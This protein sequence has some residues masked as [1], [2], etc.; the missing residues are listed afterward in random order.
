MTE[1]QQTAKAKRKPALPQGDVPSLTVLDTLRVARAIADHLAKAPS[2]PLHVAAAMGVQP[3]TGGFRAITAASVA[4]GLT[5]G[6]AWAETISLTD[7]GRRAVAPTTEGDDAAALREAVLR[8]RLIREFL[9]RYDGSKWPRDDIAANVLEQMGAPAAQT[10]RALAII[11]QNAQDLGLLTSISGVDYV[12][13]NPAGGPPA[14][15]AGPPAAAP[16]PPGP[17]PAVRPAAAVPAGPA[18]A[19]ELPP[20]AAPAP[21]VQEPPPVVRNENRRVFITHGKDKAIVEQIKMVLAYGD[22]EPVVAEEIQSTAVPVPDKV[23]DGMRACSAAVVHVGAEQRLLDQD[24]KEI[25]KLNDNV[26]IEI[27]AAMALYRRRFILL[28]EDGVRLP[29]NL[30][31]LYEVRYKGGGLDH[32]STMALLKAFAGFKQTEAT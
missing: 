30:Q 13:L 31:G 23:L 22:F 32:G 3:T 2:A 29:S 8:P 18:A 28:V 20:F 10:A 24:G 5:E 7:L 14:P 21:A 19:R 12:S 9:T 4:Y 1:P 15:P 17:A 16:P 27:G 25:Q 26:L 6:G 11:K